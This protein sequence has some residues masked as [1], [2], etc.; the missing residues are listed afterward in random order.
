V[1]PALTDVG[2]A[3]VGTQHGICRVSYGICRKTV[4]LHSSA[5][6]ISSQPSPQGLRRHGSVFLL[7]IAGAAADDRP[8]RCVHC[9]MQVRWTIFCIL[10]EAKPQFQVFHARQDTNVQPLAHSVPI[11]ARRESLSSVANRLAQNWDLSVFTPS[12]RG[13]ETSSTV[14][15]DWNPVTSPGE[16]SK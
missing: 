7:V 4:K 10:S 12:G 1:V 2:V 14:P 3:I 9:D 15:C 8:V 11:T 6:R 5:T 13:A 16:A